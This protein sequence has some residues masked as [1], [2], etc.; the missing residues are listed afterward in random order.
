M[1]AVLLVFMF[2]VSVLAWGLKLDFRQANE[3]QARAEMMQEIKR[4]DTTIAK[5]ILPITEER[6]SVLNQ[7]ISDLM[8]ALDRVDSKCIR[9]HER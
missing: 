3:A 1:W 6:L 5:G 4:I 9:V 7:R 8:A 2:M